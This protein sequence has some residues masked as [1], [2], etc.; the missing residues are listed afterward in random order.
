ML[1]VQIR[2]LCKEKL[3]LSGSVYVFPPLTVFE[4]QFAEKV[5]EERV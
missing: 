2:L 5:S 3:I 4:M 1:V